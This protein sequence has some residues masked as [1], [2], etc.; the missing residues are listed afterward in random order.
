MASDHFGLTLAPKQDDRSPYSGSSGEDYA[1]TE[2]ALRRDLAQVLAKVNL[3]CDPALDILLEVYSGMQLQRKRT[4]S[5]VAIGAGIALSSATRWIKTMEQ[6]NLIERFA[7][8]NDGRRVYL[9][10]TQ[11]A[12]RIVEQVITLI[13]R[14]RSARVKDPDDQVLFFR[15]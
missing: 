4:P 15:S 1:R 14:A 7:D 2:L 9:A 3:P 11:E 10:L 8:P 5:D 6:K 13:S 12:L